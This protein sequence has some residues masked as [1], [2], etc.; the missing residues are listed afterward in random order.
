MGVTVEDSGDGIAVEGLLETARAEKREDFER[1]AFYRCTD[2]RVV[3]EDG[4]LGCAETGEGP[5]KFQRLVDGF[6]NEL[7]DGRL[8]PGAESPGSESSRE[9]LDPREAHAPDLPGIPIEDVHAGLPEDGADVVG[10]PGFQ[11]VVAQDGEDGHPH[12]RQF[13]GEDV[14]LLGQ[15]VVRQISAENED[16][17]PIGDTRKPGLKRS[18]RVLRAVQVTDGSDSHPS[19]KLTGGRG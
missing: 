10:F 8:A 7:L 13:F 16:V 2:W 5:F 18:L 12:D 17:S 1:L 14:S 19:G 4:A 11:I 3:E 15:T 9:S 6:V